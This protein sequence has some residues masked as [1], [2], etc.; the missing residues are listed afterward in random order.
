MGKHITYI[1]LLLFSLNSFSQV[2]L[3][4]IE[5][6]SD[7]LM[8]PVT[9]TNRYQQYRYISDVFSDAETDPIFAADSARLLHWS[10]TLT[11]IASQYDLFKTVA[12]SSHWNASGANIYNAN[13]GKVGIGTT[14][15]NALLDISSSTGS[16]T[17]VPTTM[18]ISSVAS[19][20]DWDILNPW[21][22][23]DFRSSDGSGGGAGT[24]GR[25]GVLM[26]GASGA[27]TNMAFSVASGTALTEAMRINY[28][29]NV[30][31][32][33]NTPTSILHTVASGAKSANYI[34]NYLTNTA[35]SSTAS[36]T[37]TGLSVESTGT[38]NGTTAINRGLYVN[39]TGGT[40]NYS[41]IFEGGNVG[42][43]TTGPNVKLEVAGD[44]RLGLPGSA[45]K[46]YLYQNHDLNYLYYIR[47]EA[48]SSLR[49][50]IN[51]QGAG[52]VGISTGGT[53]RL[54][55]NSAGNAG[56]G[57]TNPA[58]KLHVAGDVKINTTALGTSDT[59][60]IK[61]GNTVKYRLRSSLPTTID[62]TVIN[63]GYGID[64]TESPTNT[65]TIKS[66]SAE[67][68]T[69]YDLFKT[70]ADSS[71]WKPNSTH[72]YNQNIGNVGI[73]T[74]NPSQKLDVNGTAIIDEILISKTGGL[75]TNTRVGRLSQMSVTSGYANTSIGDS[76][77]YGVTSGYENIAIGSSALK[78][79]TTSE[80]NTAI[81][82]RALWKT[83]TNKDNV[84]IGSYT[85]GAN[86]PAYGGGSYGVAIGSYALYN[87]TASNNIA[88][89]YRA[90]Y[91]NKSSLSSVAIGFDALYS[92]TGTG[93]FGLGYRA[94]RSNTTGTYNLYLGFDAGYSPTYN[95]T[96]TY[97][98]YIGRSSGSGNT[99]GGY[100]IGIGRNALNNATDKSNS[101]ALGNYAGESSLS[102]YSIY[103]GNNAGTYNTIDSS[104]YISNIAGATES[105]GI[106]KSLIYGKMSPTTA[107]QTLQLNSKVYIP[108]VA[109]SNSDTLLVRNG[110][111]ITKRLVSSLPTTTDS[112]TVVNAYGTTITESPANQFNIT[113]DSTKFAT[114]YDLTQITDNDT[115]DLSIDSLNR[116]FTIS[117]TNGGSVKF[118][119]IDTNSGG[120][121]TSVSGTSPI[122]SSGGNTP[123]ISISSDTLTS[124][125]GKQNQGVI[126]YNDKINS[127]AFSGTTTKTLTLTQQDGGT[128]SNTFTD[129]NSGGTVTSI[130]SGNGMNFTTI[131]GTGTVTMGT[132]STLTASTTNATTATSHTHAI[133]G[134]AAGT[135]TAGQ[136]A[137]WAGS[138]A[139]VSSEAGFEYDAS[140]TNDKLTV[141]NLKVT[142]LLTTNSTYLITA[143]STG[144]IG[145]FAPDPV[146]SGFLSMTAAGSMNPAVRTISAGAGISI[147]NGN[148]IS[149]NPTITNSGVT[150]LN[151]ENGVLYLNEFAK[152]RTGIASTD[153]TKIASSQRKIK[154]S[155][156]VLDPAAKYSISGNEI[157]VPEVGYYEITAIIPI[158]ISGTTLDQPLDFYA[159]VNGSIPTN[160]TKLTVN[161]EGSSMAYAL[162]SYTYSN[163]VYVENASYK[164]AIMCINSNNN[165]QYCYVNK[166]AMMTIKK[167][168]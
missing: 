68:A 1:V 8:I 65:Y 162:D 139:A 168:Y 51:N 73:G 79:L 45:K 121:V 144:D 87:N 124:W 163:I 105:E 41:A 56:I 110:N 100:N 166:P 119:D 33:T 134:F 154:F 75:T 97:N 114:T 161:K 35:T 47:W 63:S 37:K 91:N 46:I 62:S 147:A 4:Q 40:T 27:A 115:Q 64:V 29:G 6:A 98:L 88:I 117:L 146:A 9:D 15:P 101:I 138:P 96:G 66:D 50:I 158:G 108:Y 123:T 38:W 77:L 145:K 55:I 143:A 71:Y 152:F 31:I 122:L 136:V 93:N 53:E 34:G 67:M 10:D 111:I 85:M 54:S 129:N 28:Q 160:D 107:N 11:K 84:A 167:I 80:R 137:Y 57:T 142:N 165:S 148:G 132:P 39:A 74:S 126:G 164:V 157:T 140:G 23:L 112:T 30:G 76:T 52:G 17:I 22:Q 32:G 149:G 106:A 159:T 81:G 133:T 104:F 24:K 49:L 42:I 61:E 130:A 127:L 69:Q 19:G 94:G 155:V 26:A 102:N 7:S 60:L 70:V 21:G 82:Y 78:N 44:I 16:A 109:T 58:A 83:Q 95:N 156:E 120:T 113:V 131:T 59:L 25:I 12:D 20:G 116:V 99:S 90:L 14:A 141:K 151:Q 43:G 36:I 48:N 86:A 153:T 5:K 103:I 92:S 128:V 118:Q 72:I 89:G 18:M 13:T 125:R 150:L 3:K 2:R 135:G